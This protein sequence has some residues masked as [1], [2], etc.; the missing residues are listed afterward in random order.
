MFQPENYLDI[1]QSN[2]NTPQWIQEASYQEV[3]YS[4]WRF[5]MVWLEPQRKLT[6][7]DEHHCC[8]FKQ[9]LLYCLHVECELTSCTELLL[10]ENIMIVANNVLWFKSNRG[11]KNSGNSTTKGIFIPV[12][13]KQL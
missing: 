5:E 2:K 1:T 6:C 4:T 12:M 8:R 11:K 10:I 7:E 13:T 3:S 9:I